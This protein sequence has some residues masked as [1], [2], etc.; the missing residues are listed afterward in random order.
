MFVGTDR[1][2]QV[3]IVILEVHRDDFFAVDRIRSLSLETARR[4]IFH[5]LSWKENLLLRRL[6]I[7]QD[8][9]LRQS[10][11]CGQHNYHDQK[12]FFEN[13][14]D[15][16]ALDLYRSWRWSTSIVQ[17]STNDFVS[18]RLHLLI[19]WPYIRSLFL[20]VT[21]TPLIYIDQNDDEYAF[22]CSRNQVF[23]LVA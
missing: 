12:L 10:K 18:R 22:L 20:L 13:D 2:A 1:F 16:E 14:D 7:E 23:H 11:T 21:S 19:A 5:R 15:E 6:V 3:P 8:P 17:S 9:M 4:E